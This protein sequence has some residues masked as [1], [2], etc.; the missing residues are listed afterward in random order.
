M[1]N[2]Q[3]WARRFL[4]P[5]SESIYDIGGQAGAHPKLQFPQ[6]GSP[7]GFR[8]SAPARPWV[9]RGSRTGAAP[10]SR[11]EDPTVLAGVAWPASESSS[12]EVESGDVDRD[13]G[14]CPALAFFNPMTSVCLVHPP[15]ISSADRRPFCEERALGAARRLC[16]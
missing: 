1:G 16:M 11:M 9:R 10:V 2:K 12:L 3:H 6:L 4:P 14:P 13:P 7:R 8:A 15:F 5:S